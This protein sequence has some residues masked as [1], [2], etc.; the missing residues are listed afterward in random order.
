MRL[1]FHDTNRAKQA[2]GGQ[3]D[4]LAFI[5]QKECVSEM[6]RENELKGGKIFTC[7]MQDKLLQ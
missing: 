7:G 6:E 3:P 2:V 4:D 5:E 1:I